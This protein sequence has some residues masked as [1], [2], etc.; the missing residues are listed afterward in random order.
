MIRGYY[1]VK[2]LTIKRPF[3][4]VVAQFMG[5]LCL[6]TQGNYKNLGVKTLQNAQN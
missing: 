2:A 6:I 3:E 1:R 4:N 5:Q